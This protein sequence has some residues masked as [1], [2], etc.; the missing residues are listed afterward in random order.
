MRHA[1]I[2]K[3]FQSSDSIHW[4]TTYD[5]RWGDFHHTKIILSYNG[6]EYHGEIEFLSSGEKFNLIGEN[7][8]D[9]QAILF[10][11]DLLGRQTAII[12][13][14]ITD[15]RING[16]WIN[17]SNDRTYPL[18]GLARSVIPLKK[19]DPQVVSYVSADQKSSLILMKEAPGQL[20]GHLQ[21][22]GQP[23]AMSISG[24]CKDVP[25][26]FWAADVYNENGL[27][28]TIEVQK[29]TSSEL[30]F[31]F[32]EPFGEKSKHILN[33]AY[34][35][36][37]IVNGFS[38]FAGSVDI[39][40]IG[41]QNEIYTHWL[42]K[43]FKQWYEKAIEQLKSIDPNTVTTSER[44]KLSWNG[45]MDIGHI[46]EA[47]ATGVLT[48]TNQ[49]RTISQHFIMDLKKGVMLSPQSLF[50]K[51]VNINQL[52]QSKIASRREELVTESE[53]AYDEWVR[54]VIFENIYFRSDGMVLMTEYDPV[55]GTAEIVVPY[56]EIKSQ[57]KKKSIISDLI[58]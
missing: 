17:E 8:N 1:E 38:N 51:E 54:N 40:Y 13:A 5:G 46:S 55:F 32:K 20:S 47:G 36:P 30:I 25:C 53:I 49:D 21:I 41:F 31:N 16:S 24:S 10:E 19:F 18:S 26:K 9:D 28:G 12:Q 42:N 43:E 6:T 14:Q 39:A 27:V 29:S 35:A 48:L 52:C 7:H 11:F 50:K 4:T 33:K 44:Q 37:I 34:E 56:N 15:T 23:Y 3:R 22:T 58:N 57:L 45:W 2:E